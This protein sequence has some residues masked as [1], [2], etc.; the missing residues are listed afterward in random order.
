MTTETRTQH[1]PGPWHL[2]STLDVSPTDSDSYE[3]WEVRPLEDAHGTIIA[4]IADADANRADSDLL[5]A[6]PALLAALEATREEIR[7]LMVRAERRSLADWARTLLNERL[8]AI[9]ASIAQAR[10]TDA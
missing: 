8:H 7:S 5:K 6:A 4:L 1:T 9:D 2:G 3:V 10:G